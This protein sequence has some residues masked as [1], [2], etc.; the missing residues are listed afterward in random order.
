[1][2]V[3]SRD[4]L[5]APVDGDGGVSFGV[6]HDVSGEGVAQEI[7][8]E[9]GAFVAV[10]LP[11][12]RFPQVVLVVCR[13]DIA[14]RFFPG[15]NPRECPAQFYAAVRARVYAVVAVDGGDDAYGYGCVY[16]D[17]YRIAQGVVQQVDGLENS[18]LVAGRGE[19]ETQGRDVV[20]FAVNS[21]AVVQEVV[22]GG[23]R[24]NVPPV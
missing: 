19:L 24:G 7:P 22:L 23:I 17:V 9:G 2:S 11:D 15:V 1:M 16:V 20:V 13:V 5:Y 14:G 3:E 8:V 12:R 18:L 6:L 4:C 10:H 21:P